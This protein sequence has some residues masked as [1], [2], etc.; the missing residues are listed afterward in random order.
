MAPNKRCEL[1]EFSIDGLPQCVRGFGTK[2]PLRSAT[3]EKASPPSRA[4]APAAS[5]TTRTPRY[6]HR[7]ARRQT[8][9]RTRRRVCES[10]RRDA[11]SFT[12]SSWAAVAV[13]RQT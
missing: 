9:G 1:L 2:E 11:T 8:G 3:G 12:P 10:V 13:G 6:P 7:F 5:L 4:G